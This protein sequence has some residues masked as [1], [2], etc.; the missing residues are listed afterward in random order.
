M[1]KV[2]EALIDIQGKLVVPKSNNPKDRSAKYKYRSL[3]DINAAVK[4]LAAGHGCAVIYTDSFTED[5]RCV[6]TCKLVGEDGEMS[7][8]SECYVER[9]PKFMSK[10]QASGAASSYARKYAACGLFALDSGDDPDYESEHSMAKAPRKSK[11]MDPLSEAKACMW[12]AIKAYAERH[13]R[14]PNDV[15]AGVKKRPEWEAQHE[16]ADW[17]LAVAREFEEADG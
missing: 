8:T 3:E 2:L 15:L 7:A 4:P 17:L 12:N 16:S 5:G 11:V 14:D 6:S 13:D 10:E 9:T 1:S